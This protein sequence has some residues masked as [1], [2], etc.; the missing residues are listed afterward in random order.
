MLG[1]WLWAKK[2]R[3]GY[4]L[5]CGFLPCVSELVESVVAVTDF[6]QKLTFNHTTLLKV[7][8]T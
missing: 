1:L 7:A 8:P 2:Q 6:G 5:A 3:C 4:L